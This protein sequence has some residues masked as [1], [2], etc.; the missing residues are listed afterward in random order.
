[1]SGT[2]STSKKLLQSEHA[3]GRLQLSFLTRGTVV[4][5]Q[6]RAVVEKVEMPVTI[7]DR[8]LKCVCRGIYHM[9]ECTK[10]VYFLM[11]SI[12]LVI[13]FLFSRLRKSG[14][15]QIIP[16]RVLVLA[17]CRCFLFSWRLPP[18]ALCWTWP[19]V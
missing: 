12:L 15:K 13:F 14:S 6:N 4:R 17:S 2:T 16:L 11:C 3:Q 18:D 5:R 9:I 8:C 19:S 10:D 1:M 7:I